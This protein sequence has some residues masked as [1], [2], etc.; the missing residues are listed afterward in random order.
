M[1][2]MNINKENEV[3]RKHTHTCAH[4][5]QDAAPRAGVMA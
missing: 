4:T 2:G 5:E 1:K 3:R